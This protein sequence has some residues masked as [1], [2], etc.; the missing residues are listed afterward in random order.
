MISILLIC[1]RI[2]IA[3]S[4]DAEVGKVHS[5]AA[6]FHSL[7]HDLLDSAGKGA[8][9]GIPAENGILDLCLPLLHGAVGHGLLFLVGKGL[10]LGSRLRIVELIHLID[11]RIV[12]LEEVLDH[13]IDAVGIVL[14]GDGGGTLISGRYGQSVDLKG[15]PGRSIL[16]TV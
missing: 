5:F 11:Q 8:Q 14:G 16:Q 6:H 4:L 12:L 1:G 2:K 10:I 9:S 15:I 3:Q 13:I 7:H